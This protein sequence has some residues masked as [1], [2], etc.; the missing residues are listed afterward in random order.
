MMYKVLM[1]VIVAYL[2]GEK[3]ISPLISHF[4]GVELDESGTPTGN[5]ARV[6]DL[7]RPPANED[8]LPPIPN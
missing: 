2:R 8:C 1:P 6:I 7:W 5:T 4:I 3:T